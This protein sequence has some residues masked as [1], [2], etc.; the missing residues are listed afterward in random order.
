M[1]GD[2]LQ[3]PYSMGDLYVLFRRGYDNDDDTHECL[4]YFLDELKLAFS[5]KVGERGKK[6]MFNNSCNCGRDAILQQ[7]AMEILGGVG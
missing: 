3:E 1:T 6:K 5:P 4:D 7:C 2:S